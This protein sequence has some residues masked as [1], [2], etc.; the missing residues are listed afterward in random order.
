M[1]ELPFAYYTLPY[2][3]PEEGVKNV[4]ENLGE[5]LMGDIIENSPYIFHMHW[6]QF[7][8]KLCTTPPLGHNQVE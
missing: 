3:Q 2:C 7:G 4:A 6:E 8:I 1:T 5:V